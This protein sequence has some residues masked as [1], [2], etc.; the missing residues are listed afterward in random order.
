MGEHGLQHLIQRQIAIVFDD[1]RW[2]LLRR[3]APRP[4]RMLRQTVVVE[5]QRQPRWLATT[6]P[7]V[8]FPAWEDPPMRNNRAVMSVLVQFVQATR[9]RQIDVGKGNFKGS[10][11]PSGTP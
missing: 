10:T 6:S 5:M 1:M 7:S 4:S 8:D 11:K 9:T 3:I 2:R